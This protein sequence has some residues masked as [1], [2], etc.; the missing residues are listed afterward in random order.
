MANNIGKEVHH[1]WKE[2]RSPHAYQKKYKKH[3]SVNRE[4]VRTGAADALLLIVGFCRIVL[5]IGILKRQKFF[6]PKIRFNFVVLKRALII[7]PQALDIQIPIQ[8]AQLVI[9]QFAIR[10]KIPLSQI[11]KATSRLPSCDL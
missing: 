6:S 2:H 3:V 11:A 9:K 7:F 1:S 4:L 10:A 8:R 5:F